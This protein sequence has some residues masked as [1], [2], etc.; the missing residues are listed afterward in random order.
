[1]ERDVEIIGE[2]NRGKIVIIRNI[3]FKGRRNIAWCE[4]E[5][6]LKDFVGENYDISEC[7]D[8]IFISSDFPDEFAK[9][10]YTKKLKGT[11][12]KAKANAAQGVPELVEVATEKRYKD[13]LKEKHSLHAK[14][15]WY[16]YNTRFALPVYDEDQKLE[17]FNIFQAVLLIRHAHDGKRYLYD[18][19]NIKKETSKPSGL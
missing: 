13:N 12:A 8:K 16:R 2:E 5:R 17:E 18:I 10:N 1:M 14:Y 15:G 9:S 19:V 7:G 6:Y 4:V 3:L 11:L